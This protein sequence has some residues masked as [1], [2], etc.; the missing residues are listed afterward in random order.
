MLYIGLSVDFE[1]H[2]LT[3]CSR[4][5]NKNRNAFI[6]ITVYSSKITVSRSEG[7]ELKTVVFTNKQD[8]C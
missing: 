2:T 5:R 7:A 8:W 4:L 6:C 3:V 1:K